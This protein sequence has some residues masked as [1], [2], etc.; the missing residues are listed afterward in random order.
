MVKRGV[1][2]NGRT[3]GSDFLI[4]KADVGLANAENT[5][6]LAKPL[7]TA[8]QAGLNLKF[9]KSGGNLTG[10][11]TLLASLNAVGGAARG[12]AIN[13]TLNA[14]ANNDALFGLDINPIYN[15]NGLSGVNFY[16]IKHLGAIIPSSTNTFSL[17]IPSLYYS[18][19]YSDQIFANKLQ[20]LSG[21]LSLLSSSGTTQAVL[22]SS[23][24][25]LLLQNGGTFVDA[26]YRL[27]VNGTARVQSALTINDGILSKAGGGMFNFNSGLSASYIATGG[28]MGSTGTVCAG[29]QSGND[30]SAIMECRS[31]TKGFL[32]PRMT[33]AERLAIPAPATGLIVY[34]TDATEGVYTKKSSGW[35]QGV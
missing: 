17:G 7:S 26:G 23:T 28:T 33:Q 19:T 14:V 22:Y 1:R 21:G 4:T 6:D 2:I 5:S 27:D 3:V 24:G 25:N 15:S 12:Q 9:D 20:G 18:K 13:T 8:V 29:F 31:N 11:L 30:T 35:V 34:Q 16:A 10:Q 32:P